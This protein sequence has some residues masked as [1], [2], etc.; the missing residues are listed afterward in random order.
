MCAPRITQPPRRILMPVEDPDLAIHRPR[1]ASIA[2]RVERNR[3][4]QILV[5]VL[6][7][8]V[9]GLVVVVG[10]GLWDGGCHDLFGEGSPIDRT[11]RCQVVVS[12]TLKDCS[13]MVRQYYFISRTV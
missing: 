10:G 2:V 8:Q 5:A 3:L 1:R 7:V 12:T 13:K 6:Q 4:H 11:K 9:E